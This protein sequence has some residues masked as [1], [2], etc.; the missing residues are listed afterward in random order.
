MQEPFLLTRVLLNFAVPED[1][2]TGELSAVTF[3]PDGGLWVG[4]DEFQTLERLSSVSPFLY[5]DHKVYDLNDY[6]ELLA[7]EGEV[8]IEALDY[9]DSYLWVAGSHSVK[10]KKPKGKSDRKAVGRLAIVKPELNRYTLARIPVIDGELHKTYTDPA[11]PNQS[12][13]AATIDLREEQNLLAELLK[14][15]DHLAP[16]MHIPTKE[17]GL[18]VE[19]LAAHGNRVF[20]GLRGPVLRGFAIILELEVAEKIPHRLTLQPI[21]RDGQRYRKHFV[22]LNGLG[23]RDLCLLDEDLI[24]LAGPTMGLKSA[25][26]IFRLHNVLSLDADSITTSDDDDLEELMYLPFTIGQDFAE[27]LAR[28]PALGYNNGLF[29]VYDTP[30]QTRIPAPHAVYADVFRLDDADW[31]AKAVT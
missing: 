17:N 31:D 8:D 18:D 27:G 1:D 14:E 16:F 26:E 15:D 21:G 7:D 29:V 6:I 24:I 11:H 5:G 19:G 9:S 13:R 4:S 25:M 23:I 22:A 12:L 20:L 2:L 3:S 10:R 30:A 28:F